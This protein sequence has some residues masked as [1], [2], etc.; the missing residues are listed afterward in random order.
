[1]KIVCTKKEQNNFTAIFNKSKDRR[2]DYCNTINECCSSYSNCLDCLK[3]H[4]LI[5]WKII[6][7]NGSKKE[8]KTNFD[9][10]RE[11]MIDDFSLDSWIIST[12]NRMERL[13]TKQEEINHI[14][15][16]VQLCEEYMKII[17]CSIQEAYRIFCISEVSFR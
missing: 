14:N 12:E 4:K 1:M 3:K 11:L 13:I 9:I 15:N 17:K 2:P 7:D 6:D 8:A 16:V 5:E 10:I